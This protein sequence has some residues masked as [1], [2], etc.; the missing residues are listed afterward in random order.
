MDVSLAEAFIGS[1]THR[2]TIKKW[3]DAIIESKVYYNT[4]S[5][6]MDDTKRPET[7]IHMDMPGWSN[8]KGFYSKFHYQKGRHL[9][10]LRADGH[11]AY[12]RADM[13]MYP[14]NEKPQR[15][16]W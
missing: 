10:Q 15:K 6:Y 5:H 9:L 14:K 12:T 4:V 2:T 8:T 16:L 1:L 11:R 3:N 7:V 13:T